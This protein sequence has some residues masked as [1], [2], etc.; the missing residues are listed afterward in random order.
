MAEIGMGETRDSWSENF[1]SELRVVLSP[2]L[3]ITGSDFCDDT[4]HT[5]YFLM[6]QRCTCAGTQVG[7]TAIFRDISGR[8]TI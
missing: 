5:V 7:E 6:H 4:V 8:G 1:F 2:A 3:H